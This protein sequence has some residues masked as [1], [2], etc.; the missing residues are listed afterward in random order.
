MW[1]SFF[2]SFSK[3][4]LNAASASTI[5]S[6]DFFTSEGKSSA[7]IFCHFNSSRHALLQLGRTKRHT[8]FR[9]HPKCT[10]VAFGSTAREK[11]GGEPPAQVGT[12]PT[13]DANSS[14]WYLSRRAASRHF[15]VTE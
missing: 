13:A 12:A 7:S 10:G 9:D 4:A 8:P 11:T 5:A 1:P 14:R 6:K 3:S 15:R 2:S